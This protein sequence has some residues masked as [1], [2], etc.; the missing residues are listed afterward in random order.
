MKPDIILRNETSTIP[1]QHRSTSLNP[2][3]PLHGK[4]LSETYR[5]G[6]PA[7]DQ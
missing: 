7:A 1:G 2:H 6:A 3:V 5:W 4:M